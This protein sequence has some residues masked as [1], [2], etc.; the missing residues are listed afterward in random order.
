[1][2]AYPLIF[3]DT[4]TW[5]GEFSESF[6]SQQNKEPKMKRSR[7]KIETP[8]TLALKN[9]RNAKGLSLIKTSQMLKM[10]S[11]SLAFA[12]KQDK[13]SADGFNRTTKDFN[14]SMM[15][16]QPNYTFPRF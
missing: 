8:V 16:F 10:Q 11:E 1:M 12:N 15:K 7:F 14:G 9:M 2:N 4:F 13:D 6:F 3:L 5:S